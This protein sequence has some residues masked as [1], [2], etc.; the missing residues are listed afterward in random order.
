MSEE[1]KAIKKAWAKKKREAVEIAGVIHDIVE[2]AV[3]T[4][5]HE[6]PELS[7]KLVVA[8]NAANKFKEENGL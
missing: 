6:L 4:K 2:D 8:V 7:E 1:A 5:S 3:W